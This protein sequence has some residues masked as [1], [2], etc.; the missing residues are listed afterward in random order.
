MIVR[1]LCISLTTRFFCEVFLRYNL[2][3]ILRSVERILSSFLLELWNLLKW[4]ISVI[5]AG[6]ERISSPRC[7]RLSRRYWQEGYTIL[8]FLHLL[9]L[10]MIGLVW[11]RVVWN[12][13]GERRSKTKYGES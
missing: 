5:V 11:E 12:I 10:G 4:K 3:R 7:H 2:P 9:V 8:N 1:L 6:Y 13:V